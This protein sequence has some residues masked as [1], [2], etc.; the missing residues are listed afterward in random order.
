MQVGV[1]I[2]RL[3][4]EMKLRN[5]SPRTLK[6]YTQCVEY[7]LK[8]RIRTEENIQ[9]I[10][11]DLIKKLVLHLQKKWKAPKT[12]NLYKSAI[13]FFCNE[14]LWL[15]LEKLPLAVQARKLPVVLSKEEISSLISSY[16]NPKHKLMIELAY[17]CGL[18]V[19]EL[20]NIKIQDLDLDRRA[21]MI[22]NSKRA[23]DR[24]VLLPNTL[25]LRLQAIYE[26]KS[27]NDYLF[28]SQRWGKLTTTS[29]QHIFKQ[30]CRRVWIKKPAT[31]H[32]LRHSFATHLLENG[33]DIRY[34]QELLGHSNIKTT[35][36]YTHVMRKDV[37]NIQSPLDG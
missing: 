17:G 13:M 2:K 29:L 18:R 12:V 22:R 19:S 5:Y 14:V 16:K 9:T 35:Q 24:Q 11:R 30:W 20:I 25:L 8:Y 3:Q 1:Y 26:Q 10:D 23:K 21:L 28:E 33:V 27:W 31:F 4:D 15:N 7:F 37:L 6:M 34:V 32:S 36:I